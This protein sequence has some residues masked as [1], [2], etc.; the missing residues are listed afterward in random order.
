[1][2]SLCIH[3]LPHLGNRPPYLTRAQFF[4]ANFTL[5]LHSIVKKALLHRLIFF[6]RGDISEILKDFP[7]VIHC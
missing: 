2:G 5:A 1:M 7:K 6:W 3:L 4:L